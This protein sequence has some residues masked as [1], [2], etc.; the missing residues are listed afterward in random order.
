VFVV[1]SLW[2]VVGSYGTQSAEICGF[3]LRESAGKWVPMLGEGKVTWR[4]D[5]W[6]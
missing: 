6:S 2:F 5:Y 3:N 4:V 1:C